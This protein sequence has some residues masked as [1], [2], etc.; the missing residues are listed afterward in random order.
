MSSA[1]YGEAHMSII[2]KV[3]ALTV[4]ALF[5]GAWTTLL[6]DPP[7]HAPAHGWRKQHDP[8][9]VGYTGAHWDRD[10]GIR[11][12]TCDLEAVGAVVGGVVGGT[13]AAHVGDRPIATVIGVIAGAVIGAKVGREI[14]GTD[15]G[16]FGHTLEVGED[17]HRVVWTHESIGVRYELVPGAGRDRDGA[18]CRE[19]TLVTV[20]HGKRSSQSGTAC[21][22]DG[23]AWQ[24]AH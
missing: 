22:S 15:R 8:D 6:P 16:C 5:G 3:A 1:R 4:L 24:I 9:Y 13:V 19:F 11:T 23:A 20:A 14:D 2:R 17:G 12:G 10:Y 21:R 18:A 7:A